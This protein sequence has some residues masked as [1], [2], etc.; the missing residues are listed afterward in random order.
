MFNTVRTKARW[1]VTAGTALMTFIPILSLA[2][3]PSAEAKSV[4]V[5]YRAADL[6]TP[7]GIAAL[8]RHIRGA[9]AV[10][11]S[12]FDS[13]LLD[14]QILWKDCFSHSVAN[15]VHAVHNR[16]LNSYHWQRIRGWKQ[17]AIEAPI[18]LA[19][20]NEESP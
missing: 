19:T 12:S 20:Q 16:A 18:S 14:R 7:E 15:A 3:I 17:P 6:D 2:A 11:C 8:Y 13:P 1:L 4:A 10:V 9:A 5:T